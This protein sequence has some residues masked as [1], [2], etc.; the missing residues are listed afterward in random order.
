MTVFGNGYGTWVVN[1]YLNYGY[2]DFHFYSWLG[3][4]RLIKL[5]ELWFDFNILCRLMNQRNI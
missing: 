5:Y 2:W 1:D 3:N 4:D